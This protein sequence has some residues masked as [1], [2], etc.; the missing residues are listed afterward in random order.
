MAFTRAE[1]EKIN[2]RY[3]PGFD[4][5]FEGPDH[6][7]EPYGYWWLDVVEVLYGPEDED[8]EEFYD[9]ARASEAATA[10]LL[11]LPDGTAS[12]ELRD[13]LEAAEEAVDV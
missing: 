11:G 1:A 7:D 2:N 10:F 8:S 9:A 12:A 4:Q 3:D 13:A 6:P 5:S